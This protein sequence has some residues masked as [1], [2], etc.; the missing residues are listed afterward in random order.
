LARLHWVYTHFREKHQ[1]L[2]LYKKRACRG[3]RPFLFWLP[4][5]FDQRITSDIIV[6]LALGA[7]V[8]ARPIAPRIC[9]IGSYGIA[10]SLVVTLRFL[11]TTHSSTRHLTLLCVAPRSAVKAAHASAAR[12]ISRS[13]AP[14][15]RRIPARAGE[16]AER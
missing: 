14:T 6:E 10:L 15:R 13:P 12:L 11:I 8:A 16:Y 9:T 5:L 7:M 3:A 2:R 1:G 4:R